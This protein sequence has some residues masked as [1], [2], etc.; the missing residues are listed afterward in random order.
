MLTYHAY[1]LSARSPREINGARFLL[2]HPTASR[3][4]LGVLVCYSKRIKEF[5]LLRILHS[6]IHFVV[7]SFAY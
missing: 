4:W 7:F 2:S 5:S 6:F 1:L 3:D